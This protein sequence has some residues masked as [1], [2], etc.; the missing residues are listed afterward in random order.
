MK[1]LNSSLKITF[2]KLTLSLS[3]M[4]LSKLELYALFGWYF[5]LPKKTLPT[6]GTRLYLISLMGHV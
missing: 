1:V 2:H 4:S 3:K 6:N 5:D